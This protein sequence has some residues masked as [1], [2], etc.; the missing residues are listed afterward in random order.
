MIRSVITQLQ[1]INAVLDRN[2]DGI[3]HEAS[4]F[5]PSPAGNSINWIVGHLV[6]SYDNLLPVLGADPV[7]GPEQKALY[8]R[9]APPLTEP[10]KA[11]PFDDL[12]SAFATAHERVV[13][14]LESLPEERLSEPSPISPG[15]NPEET[16]GSLLSVFAFHQAYHAGQTGLARRLA[17]LGNALT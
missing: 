6:A 8:D 13:A 9:A 3:G 4:V 11:M 15:N 1:Y 14:A 12:R 16:V 2:L 10:A 17:G 5:Q 7:L